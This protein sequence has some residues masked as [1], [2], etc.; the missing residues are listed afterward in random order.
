MHDKPF[1]K[2]LSGHEHD[3]DV[4]F[5]LCPVAHWIHE[6]PFQFPLVQA[7]SLI[8]AFHYLPP[9]HPIQTT[10]FQFWPDGQPHDLV[11]AFQF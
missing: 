11:A 2:V 10:P 4:G 9:K 7:Q 1:Q 6:N 3:K 8:A 5:H